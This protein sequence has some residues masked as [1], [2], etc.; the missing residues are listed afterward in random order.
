MRRFRFR[1]QALLDT[2]EHRE[3]SLQHELIRAEAE[4]RNV[5]QQLDSIMRVWAEW[6]EQIRNHQRGPLDLTLL[7]DQLNAVNTISQRAVEQREVVHSAEKAVSDARERLTEAARWR[8]SLE[9]FRDR[10]HEQYENEHAAREIKASDEI[11]AIRAAAERID[12][13]HGANV[14]GVS[15]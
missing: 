10:L 6:E 8:R 1:L 15:R 9:R 12:G 14:T 5:R 7:Q 3:K 13:S 4:E 11:A 2:A